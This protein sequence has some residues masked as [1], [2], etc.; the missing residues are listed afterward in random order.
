MPFILPPVAVAEKLIL[1][2]FSEAVT[3]G[4]EMLKPESEAEFTATLV[5]LPSG[6]TVKIPPV[7]KAFKPLEESEIN[8][9]VDPLVVTVML[10]LE[11]K[12]AASF[13]IPDVPN[14]HVPTIAS[15]ILSPWV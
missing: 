12:A 3:V 14:D 10:G 1:S 15:S 8:V 9:A 11:I 6:L 2:S 7:I 5:M 13:G 4:S